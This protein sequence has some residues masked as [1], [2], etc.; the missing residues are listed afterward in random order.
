MASLPIRAGSPVGMSEGHV[1]DRPVILAVDPD[2][3]AV[4]QITAHLDRYADDYRIECGT[5]LDEALEKL[6]RMREAGDR[7]AVVLAAR[8]EGEL[9]AEDLLERVNRLHPHAKRGLLIEFGAWGDEETA[10]AIRR[11]MAL[12]HI[13]Y[14]VLKPWNPP[15]EL[16]HRTVSEFL[17][18]WRRAHGTGRRELTVVADQYS[19]RGFELRNLLARNGVPHAFH[20]SDS[21]EGRR[22]L[23]VCGREQSS[24]PVV[25]LPDD[26]F[27]VD[28]TNQEL[29][30]KGYRVR[31]SIEAGSG[32]FDVAVVG[33]GPA[34]LAAAVYA[35]SEGLRALVVERTSI[36]GQ[37][38]ASARIRNYLGFQRGVAGGELATRAYQQA[39]VF[40]TTFLLM[41]EVV[42]LRATE[43]GYVLEISDGTELE[44]RSVV[45][46]MGVTYRRLGI[47]AL[48]DFDGVG[49]FYGFSSSDA[50]PF[51]GGRV[52]I[53]GA[54]NSGGQ[55]AVHATRFAREVTLLCRRKSLED[56]MSQY[57]IEEVEAAGVQV[58]LETSIVGAEGQGR[59]EGLV[60]RIGA[61]G[62]RESVAADA[63]FVLIGAQPHT[64][65]LPGEIERDERGFV[66][67]GGGEHMFETTAPGVFAIGDVRA[68]SV[69]RVASAVG[70]GSVVIHQIHRYLESVSTSA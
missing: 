27:L 62:G 6:E 45:L 52:F 57:L 43:G 12:G 48:E 50:Q 40:G 23:R 17:H 8:G 69:K 9:Q 63:V 33:A 66:V 41:R 24:E 49:V 20:T 58:R 68:G 44:A 21:E 47:P 70:E 37:A 39:W 55:A 65:W 13:D 42:G 64:E 3:G 14:Y 25:L 2:P 53:V 34:G 38:G 16:F 56:N 11:S 67:T 32:V 61:T 59:L 15:D 10:S 7:V 60:L 1:D 26:S 22:L 51:A 46:A 4:A 5:S 19:P 31:T 54:G 29:A 18:E 35:S 36:G 28:P 30:E